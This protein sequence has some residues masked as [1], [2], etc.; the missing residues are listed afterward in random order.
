MG[1]CSGWDSLDGGAI[2]QALPESIT[3]GGR[4]RRMLR[5]DPIQNEIA[6]TAKSYFSNFP[7]RNL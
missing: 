3:A 4:A 5:R 6:R 7:G 2:L 1:S